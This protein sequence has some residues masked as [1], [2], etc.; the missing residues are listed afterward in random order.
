[1]NENEKSVIRQQY[2]EVSKQACNCSSCWRVGRR[3]QQSITK[4]IK[5]MLLLSI[6]NKIR[7][8]F[9]SPIYVTR[10]YFYKFIQR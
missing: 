7:R 3:P 10:C 1:M 4:F 9:A 5:R 2:G 6:R 8:H